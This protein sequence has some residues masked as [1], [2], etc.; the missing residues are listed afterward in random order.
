[1]NRKTELLSRRIET[2]KKKQ[3][4]HLEVK[5]T[6]CKIKNSL[7]GLNNRLESVKLKIEQ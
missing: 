7:Y 5:N 3:L 1:M 2:I 6:V 4:K